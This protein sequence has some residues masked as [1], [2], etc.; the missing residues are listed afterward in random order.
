SQTVS[1]LF[2]L[3]IAPIFLVAALVLGTACAQAKVIERDDVQTYIQTLVSEHG[4][5]EGYLQ[6]VFADVVIRDDIIEKISRP[7]E[8]VWTWGR[9]KKHLVD[10]ER[11]SQ[12]IEFWH[13]HKETLL[14]AEQT[15]GV[16]PEIV[17]AILGIETRYGKITGSYPVIEALTTLGFGY[18]PRASFFRKELTEAL[19]LAREEQ[20]SPADMLGSYA[21][22]MGYGQF[23]PSSYRHYAVDFDGDGRRDIWQNPVD[24]IGSIANYFAQ[25]RW[26]GSM[27][28]TMQVNFAPAGADYDF[29]THIKLTSTVGQ[30]Q[31]DGMQLTGAQAELLDADLPA[32]LFQVENG[33]GELEYWLALGDFYVITRYNRSHLYALAVHHIAAGIKTRIDESVI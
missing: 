25:H 22:A 6:S 11:I 26:Q 21:G 30:L 1:A 32:K 33:A 5:D 15:Y 13:E 9:Y 24:A 12:G 29:N 16:A 20:K 7:A 23:I 10:E 28:A 17:L 27:P 19:L 31:H 8:K 3:A 18:P 2:T 14:R 4:F